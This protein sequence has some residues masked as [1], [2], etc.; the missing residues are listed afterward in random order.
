MWRWGCF[1]GRF[2][3]AI[4]I[5]SVSG[6][7]NGQSG[8]VAYT[9][10]D[11]GR[12][13][14]VTY[15]DG[16]V[17]NYTYDP[18]GN[19]T[20][21][22]VDTPG[23]AIPTV[24][25]DTVETYVD[26]PATFDP[27]ANDSDDDGD[28]LTI[29]SVTQGANGTV[30]LAGD[31]SSVTYTPET[32]YIGS[33]TFT[34]TV[35]D[36]THTPA[37]GNVSVAVGNY[38][39]FS[40]A[41]NAS[42]TEGSPVI[43]TVSKSATNLTSENVTIGTTSP[44]TAVSGTDYTANSQVLTFAPSELSKT[45]SVSIA[46]DAVYESDE[47][48]TVQLSLPSAGATLGTTTRTGTISNNSPGPAFSVNDASATESGIITF[49]VTKSGLTTLSH[50]VNYAT[51]NGSAVAGSDYTSKSGTL[52]FA[53]GDTSKT[54]TVSTT[55]DSIDE[56]SETLQMNLSAETG[57]AT[58]NDAQGIGTIIDDDGPPSFAINNTAASEGN[59]M[60]FTVTKTGA[61]TFSYS[62][63]YATSSGSAISGTDFTTASGTLNF[64]TTDM[65]K[66]FTVATVEDGT[67]ENNET[68]TATLS[69]PT[70]GSTITDGTGT[71][72]INNDDAAPSFAINNAQKT[73]GGVVTFTVTKSG[74]TALSHNV[75]HATA[76]NSTEAADYTAASGTL[77]FAAGETAK[78]ISITT[79]DDSADEFTE[80]FY[81]NLSNAT[82][83]ATFSDNQGLG[84]IFDNDPSPSFAIN[85]A[86]ATEGSPI[87]FTITK[88]GATEKSHSITYATANGSAAAGSDYNAISATALNF[89][90]AQTSKT[91]TVTTID[92]STYEGDETF[93]VNLSSATNGATIADSQGVGTIVENETPNSPPDAVDDF[94]S[95]SQWVVK[96]FYVLSN[97]SDPDG[98]PLTIPSFSNPTPSAIGVS[99]GCSN[100]CL[101]VTPFQTGTRYITYTASDGNGGT[102]TAVL[103]VSVS[104][105]GGPPL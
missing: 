91:V 70:G 9:Y 72:T 57:G 88:T 92:D 43:F 16:T 26:A 53:A 4:I 77:T 35:T 31:G 50:D 66:T 34:Y 98:D 20:L 101:T 69:A 104:G 95:A 38:I 99:I 40:I 30:T 14:S 59:L 61:T 76:H 58:I 15:T 105:G 55:Q 52:T 73:E 13:D 84:T 90:S 8:Q 93:N 2:L 74:S 75:T 39:S 19:R 7:A 64:G 102:D 46:S 86:F 22:S 100:T 63:N 36:G 1:L 80:T 78:P 42:A 103:R 51:A 62:V 68:L 18:A 65:S 3:A 67:Y 89:T 79:T 71:G 21:Q 49:T 29:I 81:V 60:T 87:T 94:G 12:L 96:T 44:G 56:Q 83:A 6:S 47:T 45:F 28:P 33:D 23:D 37:P 11:L 24:V 48:F 5:I 82:N 54:V 25:S 10:D 32:G 17:V 41:A 85:N 97:D 27:R